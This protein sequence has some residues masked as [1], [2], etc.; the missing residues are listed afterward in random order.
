MTTILAPL[1]TMMNMT[2]ILAPLETLMNMTLLRITIFV[3]ADEVL[4]RQ[5]KYF[6]FKLLLRSVSTGNYCSIFYS[7]RKRFALF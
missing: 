2:T 5:M 6:T 4:L 3:V 7:L 1:E